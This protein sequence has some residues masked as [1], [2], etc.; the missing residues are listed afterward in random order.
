MGNWL[1]DWR[2][3]KKHGSTSSQEESSLVLVWTLKPLVGAEV[4]VES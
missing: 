3:M 2:V 4:A 1:L